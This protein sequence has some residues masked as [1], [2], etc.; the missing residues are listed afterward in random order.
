MTTKVDCV[1]EIEAMMGASG[2]HEQAERFY[3]Y[4]RVNDMLEFGM[5]GVSLSEIDEDEFAF[6]WNCVIEEMESEEPLEDEIA[7]KIDACLVPMMVALKGSVAR[8]RALIRKLTKIIEK[9]DE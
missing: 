7:Q 8:K 3:E 5:E 9:M 4:L 1:Q 6:I 2:T